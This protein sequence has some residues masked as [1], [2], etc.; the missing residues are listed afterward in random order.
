MVCVLCVCVCVLKGESREH[1]TPHHRGTKENGITIHTHARTHTQKE[2]ERE[3]ER[4]M[5]W[6]SHMAWLSGRG[7][8]A[9]RECVGAMHTPYTEKRDMEEVAQFCY[10]NVKQTKPTRNSLGF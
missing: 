3:R 2:R 10:V 8:Q 5:V 9:L 7:L 4:E 6:V 1:A